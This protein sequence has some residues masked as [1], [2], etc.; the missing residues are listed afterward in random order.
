MIA[1]SYRL[2]DRWHRRRLPKWVD[3]ARSGW[4]WLEVGGYGSLS[5]GASTTSCVSMFSTP[6]RSGVTPP[7][8]G[9]T[10]P[11]SGVTPPRSGVT[12]P[13]SGRQLI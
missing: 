7:R 13:R 6:P 1:E 2:L 10:P 3:M 5:V 11:R 8:S 12:P 9:V 4:M